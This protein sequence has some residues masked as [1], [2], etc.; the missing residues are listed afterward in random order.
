VFKT[1]LEMEKVWGKLPQEVFELRYREHEKRRK[2]N[3][4]I[5]TKERKAILKEHK[6]NPKEKE[7]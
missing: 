1:K 3:L 6:S 2:H 7:L 5:V 4:Q